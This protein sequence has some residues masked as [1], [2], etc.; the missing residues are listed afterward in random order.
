MDLAS[1]IRRNSSLKRLR[2][3]DVTSDDWGMCLLGKT[4][5]VNGG[6]REL[7][8]SC[9]NCVIDDTGWISLAAAISASKSIESLTL[10][11]C[12]DSHDD[13]TVVSLAK[14]IVQVRLSIRHVEI[15]GY[16]KTRGMVAFADALGKCTRLDRLSLVLQDREAVQWRSVARALAVSLE[17]LAT[18]RSLREFSLSMRGYPGRRNVTVRDDGSGNIDDDDYFVSDEE[19]VRL[20]EILTRLNGAKFNL[21]F[22]CQRVGP[23]GARALRDWMVLARPDHVT[24]CIMTNNPLGGEGVRAI[25]EGFCSHPH[26]SD[27]SLC[28]CDC[29]D[30]ELFIHL[31]DALARREVRPRTIGISVALSTIRLSTVARLADILARKDLEGSREGERDR[32]MLFMRSNEEL[33]RVH[34]DAILVLFRAATTN[35]HLDVVLLAASDEA[36]EQFVFVQL[37]GRLERRRNFIDA[38]GGC[39]RRERAADGEVRRRR[40]QE[41]A[42]RVVNIPHVV[43]LIGDYFDPMLVLLRSRP[44]KDSPSFA[45]YDEIWGW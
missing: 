8:I 3:E 44:R 30:E 25:L 10:L 18:V 4:I 13:D 2:F 23:R 28:N 37:Y 19:A 41:G 39:D 26:M 31:A 43:S 5:T 17:S 34:E 29:S 21:D 9:R 16:F 7:Y 45:Y 22:D 15:G 32:M 27:W 1:V 42:S 33:W 11:D 20:A 6:V 12:F 24:G 40:R 36:R 35:P 38:V 14:S